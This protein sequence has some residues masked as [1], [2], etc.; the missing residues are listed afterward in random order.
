MY[1]LT[2][3][4]LIPGDIILTRPDDPTSEAIRQTTGANFP[5]AILYLGNYSCIDSDG[6]GVRSQNIQR[7]A[8]NSL[9]HGLVLRLNRPLTADEF[10]IIETF[11]RLRIGTEFSGAEARVSISPRRMTVTPN[12]NRQFC[13]RFVSQ[14]YAAAGIQLVDNTDY[15]TPE[16]V[17]TSPQL[18]TV[19]NTFHLASD[20]ERQIALEENHTLSEQEIITG[21][22]L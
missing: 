19:A 1:L 11:A 3:E 17:R 9:D 22:M 20:E 6:F 14:S 2:P 15:C 8:L 12:L 13:T 21:Q 5:H 16:E 4:S 7:I 18:S 10:N